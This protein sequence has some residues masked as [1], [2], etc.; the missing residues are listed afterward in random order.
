MG[1]FT[2][3]GLKLQSS[4]ANT[5]V[6]M[7]PAAAPAGPYVVAIM[8]AIAFIAE[9]VEWMSN[10]NTIPRALEKLQE[11]IQHL[12][13]LVE[14]LDARMDEF[15]IEAAVESNRQTL[16]RLNDYLDD[17][18]AI[19]SQLLN[20]PADIGNSVDITNRAG[21][22]VDKFLRDDFE[23]WRWTD[24]V[25]KNFADPHTGEF[26]EEPDLSLLRFK[27]L[28]TLPV[29]VL[30]VLTWL[31]ARERTVRLGAGN[32]LEGDLE[33]VNRHLNAVSVRPV[34]RKLGPEE[35]HPDGSI[36]W[37]PVPVTIQENI[38]ARIVSI[39]NSSNLFPQDRMCH[40]WF[41]LQNWMTGEW[42]HGGD[43]DLLMES[44]D[45]LCTLDPLHVGPPNS[46][47][48]VEEAAG[49]VTLEGLRQTIERVA[50]S[51]SMRKPF[52]GRFPNWVA[53]KSNYYTVNPPGQLLWFE[54]LWRS[55]QPGIPAGL[56]GPRPIASGWNRF[57]FVLPAGHKGI[58]AVEQDGTLL[59]Y[60]HEGGFDGNGGLSNPS[61]VGSGWNGFASIVAGGNGVLYAMDSDG[62][63]WWYKHDGFETG[64]GLNTWRNRSRVGTGWTMFKSIFSG[65]EEGIL[66]GVRPDG[67]LVWYKHKGVNDGAPLWE[68][69]VEVGTGWQ[70]F[71]HIF[72]VGD[73]VIYAKPS[74]APLQWYRHKSWKTATK[75]VYST[76]GGRRI[77]I[78]V[79]PIPLWEGPV[80]VGDDSSRYLTMFGV[81]PKPLSP[82]GDVR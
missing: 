21:L 20:L 73:G 24:V 68:P 2:E 78:S 74:N 54:H 25:I 32:Q 55:D 82:G 36:K 7:M 51:G 46:E 45:V 66:Y 4:V 63:L 65:G 81:L 17:V 8:G 18:K 69:P 19:Q 71:T 9:V 47:L 76:I 56:S 22:I 80:P 67:V 34:F 79:G 31:S 52:I 64:G 75:W 70:H 29:Y 11:A 61:V 62:T 13:F 30:A 27:N 38:K 14:V 16:A 59:W 44:N 6:E 5:M 37:T 15:V 58:Y 1:G 48:E 26:R 3:G 60:K 41:D 49:T 43:F 28:P 42:K 53:S 77:P 12:T 23:I 40:F 39:I 57:K 33:R 50:Q 35:L 10:D 72:G